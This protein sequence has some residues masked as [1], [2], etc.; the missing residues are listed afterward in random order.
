MFRHILCIVS[1][2]PKL[3]LL[4]IKQIGMLHHLQRWIFHFMKRQE[5]L[6]KYNAIWLS[7]PAYH[8]LTPKTK[9]YEEVCQWNGKEMK[10]MSQYLL[11]V[12]T[13]HLSGGSPAQHPIFNR[14]LECMQAMLEFYMYAQYESHVNA[15]LSYMEDA[16]R[17]F[18]T[19]K[20][21]FLLGRASK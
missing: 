4:H 10:E 20:D 11:E 6:N 9:S 8:N 12:V 21:V 19:F 1:D 14:T 5:R 16:L 17:C 7:T 15:T 18:H 3:D 2:L 13:Q